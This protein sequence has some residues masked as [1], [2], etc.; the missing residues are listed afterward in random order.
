LFL[1]KNKLNIQYIYQFLTKVCT[2]CM[3]MEANE[4]KNSIQSIDEKTKTRETMCEIL[5]T[6]R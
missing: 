3:H 6:N 4:E 1:L 5:L 2:H